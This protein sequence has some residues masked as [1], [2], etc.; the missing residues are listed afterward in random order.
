MA[1]MAA[2]IAMPAFAPAESVSGAGSW[3]IVIVVA[4]GLALA[5]ET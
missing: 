3:F 2:P 1:T 5:L 4:V